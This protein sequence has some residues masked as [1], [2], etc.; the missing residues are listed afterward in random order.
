[1]N[2]KEY[3]ESVEKKLDQL[4]ANS[5]KANSIMPFSINRHLNGLYDLNYGMDV[6]AWM[7]EPRELWQLVNSLY[8]LNILGGLKNDNMEA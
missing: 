2:N 3:I 7:L 1:M 4:N 8:I 6:I 5:L